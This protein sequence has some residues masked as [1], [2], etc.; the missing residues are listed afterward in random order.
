MWL[1]TPTSDDVK[2][3]RTMVQEQFSIELSETEARLYAT[4]ILQIYF[5]LPY[6]NR[7][8]RP[9]INRKR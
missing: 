4:N 3:F 5:L 8:L 1:P 7:T 9:Q 2:K 6:A